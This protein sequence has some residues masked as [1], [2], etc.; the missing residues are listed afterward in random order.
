MKCRL[1]GY[2]LNSDKT[3]CPMCGT[4]VKETPKVSSVANTEIAWNTKD[5]PKPKQLED[6]D[7]RWDG[8]FDSYMT[9]DASE[10][11]V[12]VEK[13]AIESEKA[14]ANDDFNSS[15]DISNES[16]SENPFEL[17]AKIEDS[18]QEDLASNTKSEENAP[19]FD[20]WK[21]PAT[22]EEPPVSLWYTQNFTA[23]GVMKT[24]PAFPIAQQS[25]PAQ[26]PVEAAPTQKANAMPAINAQQTAAALSAAIPDATIQYVK[27][28]SPKPAYQD[29][30]VKAKPAYQ[31][32]SVKAKPAYQDYSVKAKPAFT[33]YQ[34]KET[35]PA[36]DEKRTNETKSILKEYETYK[37]S[38]T[39]VPPLE[40]K[41]PERFNTFIAK[42]EE[43]QALLDREYDRIHAARREEASFADLGINTDFTNGE[44][45]Q[46]QNIDDFE[47]SIFGDKVP[48]RTQIEDREKEEFNTFEDK[49]ENEFEE[50]VVNAQQSK[51]PVSRFFNLD[52]ENDLPVEAPAIAKEDETPAPAVK[53]QH[54]VKPVHAFDVDEIFPQTPLK[55]ESD[56]T[57]IDL[58][59]LIADPL[60]PNF[61]IHTIELTI[62]QLEQQ[63]QQ[64]EFERQNRQSRLE[65]MKAARE[66]YF[67]FLDEENGIQQEEAPAPQKIEMKTAARPAQNEEVF[68]ANGE[69]KAARPTQNEEVFKANVERKAVQAIQNETPIQQQ[70]GSKAQKVQIESLYEPQS[71][72][73]AEA[74]EKLQKEKIEQA[75]NA[76]YSAELKPQKQPV[77]LMPD[78]NLNEK[79]EMLGSAAKLKDQP[80]EIKQESNPYQPA[81][82]MGIYPA[83][84]EQ[85]AAK[86]AYAVDASK[87]QAQTVESDYMA[88]EPKAPRQAKDADFDT[89]IFD[90]RANQKH[91]EDVATEYT[92]STIELQRD[93]S[94]IYSNVEDATRLPDE[95]MDLF[96][97]D[98]NEEE[99]K[100]HRLKGI[101][102][103]LFVL[104]LVLVVAEGFILGLQRFL[105]N[106]KI[107]AQA[108]EMQEAVV[109]AFSNLFGNNN[110]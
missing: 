110:E 73:K 70:A 8:E 98:K 88:E 91:I 29:Y 106:A 12:S 51:E 21:M 60:D 10:G 86:E 66:A 67:K 100:P 55:F 103:F 44:R 2:E 107:T 14:K 7:M 92:K 81:S 75:S 89:S 71:V 18:V 76:S 61:D 34:T 93:V 31:D 4:K 16:K 38:Y 45:V 57:D 58:D 104:I 42:N 78:F 41:S 15:F 56:E 32:Y 85:E 39:D 68:K 62:R 74:E 25:A 17:P 63:V 77:P 1:C 84:L 27:V 101:L 47:K 6:I 46:V 22:K 109:D 49:R 72:L 102:R 23:S 82:Q 43:F 40:R 5:F 9:K 33:D 53:P 13:P 35:R 52:Q 24:G 11:Y 90:E 87:A 26:A 54:N 64:N 95:L 94:S 50:A 96:N 79:I 59:E 28:E 97:D 3:Y 69:R 20:A 99:E 105:P 80:I 37:P 108:V 36:F 65:A 30:S 83:E 19:H 48:L